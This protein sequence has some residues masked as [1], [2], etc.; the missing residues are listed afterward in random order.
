MM[1]DMAL[2]ATGIL[3]L[4]WMT[5]YLV[6]ER[7]TEKLQQTGLTSWLPILDIG[8]VVYLLL[9]FFLILLRPKHAWK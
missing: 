6:M 8:Y 2:L 9:I 4:V 5:K 7:V 1:P 3:G